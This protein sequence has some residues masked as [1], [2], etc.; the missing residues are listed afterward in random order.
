MD[1]RCLERF[2]RVSRGSQRYGRS[3]Y[4]TVRK[5]RYGT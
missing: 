5:P 3:W 4:R 1:R 2:A